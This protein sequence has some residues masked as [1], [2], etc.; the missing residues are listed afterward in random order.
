MAA[1]TRIYREQGVSMVPTRLVSD[2]EGPTTEGRLIL[3]PPSAHRSPW[4]KRFRAV[5]TAFCVRWM[6]VRGS[7]AG[8]AITAGSSCRTTQTGKIFSTRSKNR[9]A[10]CVGDARHLRHAGSIPPET[11]RGAEGRSPRRPTSVRG[12]LVQAFATLF[13]QLDQTTATNERCGS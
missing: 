12:R 10:K 5:S 4:M 2:A 3:A 7:V 6:A 8:V 9:A 13:E 11:S 1:L